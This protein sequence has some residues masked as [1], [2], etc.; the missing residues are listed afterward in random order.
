MLKLKKKKKK[1]F[2]FKAVQ[3]FC[4]QTNVN[5]SIICSVGFKQTCSKRLCEAESKLKQ[6]VKHLHTSVVTT[7]ELMSGSVY[8]VS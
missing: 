1:K 2:N 4:L 5:K 3:R 6:K 8:H 7:V